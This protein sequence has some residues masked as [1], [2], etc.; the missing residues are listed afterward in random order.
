MARKYELVFK[1]IFPKFS[2]PNK[3]RF[4]G[5][6]LSND[7]N[8]EKNS[9]IS[10][11]SFE[12]SLEKIKNSEDKR[13]SII[14]KNI[15]NSINKENLNKLLYGVGNINYLYLPFDKITKKNLGFAFV[16]MVNYKSIIQLYNKIISLNVDSNKKPMEIYYSKIQGKEELIKM[17]RKK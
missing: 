4:L 12:I 16:N 14:L 8:K 13:T 7:I 5:L 15:P 9:N 11:N 2:V 1:Y 3:S 17:F 10:I 6:S